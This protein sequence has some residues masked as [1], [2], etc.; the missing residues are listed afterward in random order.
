[1]KDKIFLG[2]QIVSGLMLVMFGL[3]KFLHFI[4]MPPPTPEMGAYMKA[5]MA[6]G[7]IFPVIAVIEI[8]AGLAFITN[9][10]AGLMAIV[11]TPIIVNAL[12]AHIFL[13][14]S[15]AGGAGFILFAIIIVMIRHKDR[16]R[17]IF[18]A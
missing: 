2:I 9:K 6:T 13:D 12:L 1:M 16:Y 8:I 11:V 5:L 14:P 18:N 4:P 3:N 15:G 10:F 7:F 17:D